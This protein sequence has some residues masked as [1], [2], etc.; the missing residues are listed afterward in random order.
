MLSVTIT[1]NSGRNLSGQTVEAF[2]TSIE[3]AKPFSVGINCALG[4]TVMLPF[5]DGLHRVNETWCSIYANAGLPNAFGGYDETPEIFAANMMPY[6]DRQNLNIVGGCCGTFP[7]HI[8]AVKKALGN[9]RPRVPPV[10]EPKMRLSGLEPF[11]QIPATFVNIGERCN[12]LGSRKFK[13]LIEQNKWDDALE[14][15]REQVENGAQILDFNFDTDLLDGVMAMGKFMR[16]CVTDPLISKVPFMIDSSKWDVIEEGLK[17]VQGKCIINST[18]LKAGEETFLKHAKCAM[19]HGAALVVMAFDEEGQATSC[20]DKVRISLRAYELL[21]GIGFNLHDIIYDVN[22][23]TIATGLPEHNNYGVD[24]IN[25]VEILHKKCPEVSFSGGLSNLSFSFRGLDELREA[26]HSVF[27]YLAIPKGLNMSIVN[28]GM[29]PVYSDIPEE[30]Q[31][32]CEQ[33]IMNDSPN[34]DHVERI[35]AVAEKMAKEKEAKKGQ[36]KDEK[37]EAEWR[38]LPLQERITHA[39]VKG[40]DK[41]IVDDVKEIHEAGTLIPL[42]IIEGPLMTGVNVVGDLFGAGKMFLPQVIKSARVMKRGVGHLIPFMEEEKEREAIEKG[43]DP[44]EMEAQNAGVIVIATVKGDV[45]DIGKN[46]VSVVLGCNNFK[47]IDLGVMT[48]WPNIIE[49]CKEHNADILGL[50]GLITPSLDEMVTVAK[51][52]DKAGLQ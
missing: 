32:L 8:A 23:L 47:V 2:Y 6:A 48:P 51:E 30:M 43:L 24:V 39:L 4:A 31:E 19:N 29:L 33:V 25:A 9:T 21:K 14:I 16:L 49:A 44:K 52:M 26:M 18:S 11:E 42:E 35:L 27:L 20:E 5:Y 15:A 28:A 50:S 45:H 17:W 13:R 10:L 38:K 12:L 22:V 36:P 46:I 7:S 1:D 41:H 34:N 37:Q 40:I 3:H